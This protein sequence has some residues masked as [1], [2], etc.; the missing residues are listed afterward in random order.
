M[1]VKAFTIENRGQFSV[2]FEI[3]T[4]SNL[5]Q[6]ISAI[7]NKTRV[8]FYVLVLD[9]CTLSQCILSTLQCIGGQSTEIKYKYYVK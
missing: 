6:R 4:Y 1:E 9:F 8:A 5:S 2:K 7:V 3:S